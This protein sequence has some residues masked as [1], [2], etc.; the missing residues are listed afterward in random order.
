MNQINFKAFLH[1]VKFTNGKSL[2]IVVFC[3]SFFSSQLAFAQTHPTISDNEPPIILTPHDIYITS[4]VPTSV[5]FSVK[6]LDN[7]DGKVPVNCDKISGQIF[8]MGKTVVRCEAYDRVG[9]RSQS[10]F[11]VTVGYE[12]VQIPS[13]V[14]DITKFWINNSIDDNTYSESIRYLIQER[15]VKVPIVKISDYY[16]TEIPVWVK[17]NAHYW[18]EG[19]ITDDEY[20]IMLQWMLNRGLIRT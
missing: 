10:S 19:K 5:P 1:Q 12:I 18:V 9:N 16:K 15:I 8:K 17:T 13:W 11:V 7:F 2:L 4:S 20:S 3:V 14:K 6:A